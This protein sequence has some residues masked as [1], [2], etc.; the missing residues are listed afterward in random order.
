MPPPAFSVFIVSWNVR[1]CLRAC[2]QAL[3]RERPRADFEVIV[4]DNA[5]SDNSGEMVRQE[6]SW[7]KLIA[8]PR[9]LGFAAANN[10]AARAARANYY[11]LLNPDTVILPGFFQQ[12]DNFFASHR[13]AGVVGSKITNFDGSLQLSVRRFPTLLS[14]ILLQLKIARFYPFLTKHYLASDF[15]YYQ[16]AAVEQVMGACFIVPSVC[17]QKLGGFDENFF[18]W[19]E[20]VDFCRRL[21]EAGGEVWYCPDIQVKHQA[22]ASFRQLNIFTRHYQFSRSAI[23]Y[24][25][26]HHSIGA[27]VIVALASLP[28]LIMAYVI[29]LFSLP[30]AR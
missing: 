11:V 2:L 18:V 14:Q 6:F 24:F 12:A 20:E 4:V 10:E 5:S 16:A 19:F 22:G 30:A 3:A 8:S 7:V 25:S 13:Q 23:Y 17:W 26:K 29:K 1:D 21:H 15:T 27:G 9:N 28:M